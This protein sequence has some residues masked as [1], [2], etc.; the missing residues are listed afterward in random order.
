MHSVYDSLSF[1]TK[2]VR[3]CPVL[4]FPSTRCL[5]TWKK[6]SVSGGCEL[7]CGNRVDTAVD[8]WS[9][10]GVSHIA[11]RQKC[12]RRKFTSHGETTQFNCKIR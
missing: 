1:P 2:A 6:G 12:V 8:L 4:R 7:R 3:H 11:S 5:M 10:H 9:R